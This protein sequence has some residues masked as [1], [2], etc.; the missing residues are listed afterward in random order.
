MVKNYYLLVGVII[1]ILALAPM[2]YVIYAQIKE[3]RRP[4]NPLTPTRLRL[5][6]LEVM[7]PLIILPG[8]PRAVQLLSLPPVNNYAKIV[9]ITNRLPY[10][11][12]AVLLFVIYRES[13]NLD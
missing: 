9:S 7:F 3:V 2:V 11:I 10:L 12:V 8:L 6:I 1:A 13:I 5:L 4:K